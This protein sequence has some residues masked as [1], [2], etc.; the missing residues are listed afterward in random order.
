M[1][2]KSSLVFS[3]CASYAS[4][5][6]IPP[7]RLDV[8]VLLGAGGRPI[9]GVGM[10]RV[11]TVQ[12]F[13]FTLTTSLG[14][15]SVANKGSSDFTDTATYD[16]SLSPN[17]KSLNGS[18]AMALGGGNFSGSLMK[19]NCSLSTNQGTP[20]AYTNQTIVLMDNQTQG[21]PFENGVSGLL[22]LGTLKKPTTAAGFPA[23]FDDGI[24]GQYY[25]R[26]P[27]ATNFTFGM[28]LKPSPVIPGNG[29][30]LTIPPGAKSLADS[31][32]GTIHW[33]QPD[34][35]AY[36]QDKMQW[37]TVQSG[38]SSGYLT[39]NEQPDLTV[40]LDGW[41]AKIG[42]NN[43]ANG[44]GILV[45]IDPYY[46]GIYMPGSQ[47][48]LIHDA[49]PGSNQVSKSTISGQTVSWEVPCNT[50]VQFTVAINGQQ[51]TVDQSL[52]IVN[53]GDGT[54]ISLIEGFTDSA[55]TQ[56]IFGQNWLSQLYVIFNIPKDGDAA[57]AFAPRSVS[58]TKSR[59]IGAIVGGT[60][61]G[62]AGVVGLGLLAFYFI[63]RRQDNS[64]FKR[65]AELEEEHK[66]ASTV[67]PYTFG[68]P[69][70]DVRP[71]S[72]AVSGYTTPPVSPNV[73]LLNQ[74]P[75]QLPPS[76][77]E[78]S[79]SG[80]SSPTRTYPREKAGYRQDT[81]MTTNGTPSAPVSPNNQTSFAGPSQ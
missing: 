26:N 59:D 79:E 55:V 15:S 30:S 57:L 18:P 25:I 4:A 9:L 33:L 32:V 34:T 61:G 81:M 28:A 13:N 52:I 72:Y 74:D 43:V 44:D 19:E 29:S 63:R 65:A 40:K 56:Y 48:R 70:P 35:S 64:F 10:V 60:V 7:S 76:Y 39:G 31:N 3:L 62:V 24:Y 41:S 42:S 17:A 75:G 12:H 45:N 1:F 21:S 11:G 23:T 66:V 58:S 8:P 77:E 38:I 71:V 20:W 46:S 67:Q 16:I 78:A 6:F 73:P 2:T 22:G 49:I 69:S 80:V 36:Q 68:A 47:A 53:Q 51:F 54:C 37:T 5:A 50:N 27:E 14:Y